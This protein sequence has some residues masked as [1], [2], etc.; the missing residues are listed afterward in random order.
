MI[1]TSH[2][3]TFQMSEVQSADKEYIYIVLSRLFQ[4]LSYVVFTM[5][6]LSKMVT[7]VPKRERVIV[8][9][10]GTLF[11]LLINSLQGES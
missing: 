1:N 10:Y 9:N 4:F 5:E 3:T 8:W 6:S 11:K 2:M 7:V